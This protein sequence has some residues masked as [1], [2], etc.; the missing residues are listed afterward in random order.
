MII[1]HY[2]TKNGHYSNSNP[3]AHSNRNSMLEEQVKVAMV[4]LLKSVLRSQHFIILGAI[5]GV[6]DILFIQSVAMEKITVFS[7]WDNI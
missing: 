4:K 5:S 6:M 1:V 7:I 3:T 2:S